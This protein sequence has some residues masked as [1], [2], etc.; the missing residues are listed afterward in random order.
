MKILKRKFC[1]K[2]EGVMQNWSEMK[3]NQELELFLMQ[4]LP[5]VAATLCR[6][7]QTFLSSEEPFSE[8]SQVAKY[9][10]VSTTTK[11]F[12]S[13]KAVLVSVN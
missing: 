5:L 9:F 6:C 7:Q 3:Y 13:A 2:F 11:I 1:L 4:K 10:S 12:P 8:T